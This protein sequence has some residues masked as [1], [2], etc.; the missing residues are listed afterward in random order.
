MQLVERGGDG[1]R[2]VRGTASSLLK[3]AEKLASLTI[4]IRLIN[5]KSNLIDNKVLIQ[6]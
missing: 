5:R 4:P 2:V 6:D 3:S 1:G